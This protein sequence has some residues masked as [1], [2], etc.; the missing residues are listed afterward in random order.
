VRRPV[1]VLVLAGALLAVAYAGPALGQTAILNTESL[2]PQDVSGAFLSLNLAADLQGGNADV[3]DLS[4]NGAVGY[5]GDRNW[6][7]LMGGLSYLSASDSV[8]TDDRYAQLRYSRFFTRRTRS[9]HFVQV[10]ASRVQLL[11]RRVLLGS[12]V[13][14][15]FVDG[16]ATRLDVGAGLMWEHERLDASKLPA[17]AA[18]RS[19]DWRG[20]LLAVASQRISASSRLSGVMYVEPRVDRPADVRVL[21]ELRLGASVTKALTLTLAFRWRH[22]SRPPPS[23]RRNDVELQAGIGAL[24]R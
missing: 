22:D 4:G 6:V 15:A 16:K 21:S 8:S 5:R 9:F 24:I 23:V 11:Q 7:V 3:A 13:R 1:A 20:D 12:G 17:G 19:T 18:A 10:Q 14:H 2:Q